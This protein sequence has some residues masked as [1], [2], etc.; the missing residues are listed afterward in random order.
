MENRDFIVFGLQPWDI[1][2]GSTCKYTATE[3]AKKNRVLFVNPPIVRSSLLKNKT[4]PQVLKRKNIL[5]GK[6]PDLVQ[7]SDRLWVLYP[8]TIIESINWIPDHRIFNLLNR[9]NEKRFASK[10]REAALNLGFSNILIIDDNSMIIGYYLKEL[11]RPNLFI[12]LLRDAVI[13]VPYHAR[14]GAFL[15]P[16]LIRKSDLTVTNSDFFCNYARS[17]NLNSFMIGQ[18]CDLTLFQDPDGKLAIPPDI[19]TIPHP[20]IG[21]TGALTSIRLDI[22]ILVHIARNM[23]DFNLVLVGPEDEQFRQS[24]LHGFSNVFFL[25]RKN[26]EDLPGY[27]K[28][29]DIAVNPQIINKITDINYPLKIDEYLAMG[30]PVVATKTTFMNYFRDYA[31]LPRTKEEYVDYIEMALRENNTELE[32]KRKDFAA[33]HSWENFVGKI[34][35]HANETER[36]KKYDKSVKG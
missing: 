4:S 7:I 17:F 13:L 26:P 20:I 18:G 1:N 32:K 34:Y 36:E 23:P 5:K 6:E 31:Y 10:I 8:K 35:F 2:I 24:E 16:I 3:I 14:H 28:A 25:G 19:L 27:I 21:Y 22:S 12:Y 15:E 33:T 30:K 29:F 9:I 11:L